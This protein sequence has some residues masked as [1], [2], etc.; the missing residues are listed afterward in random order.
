M[1]SLFKTVFIIMFFSVVTRFVGF[2]FRIYMSRT[3]GAEALGQYQVSFSVFM[4]LLTIVSSGLPFVM[5][6]LTAQYE[7]DKDKTGQHKMVTAGVIIGIVASVVLCGL[8]LLFLPVLKCVFADDNCITILLILLPALVFSSVYSTIRGNVWGKGHYF[9]L[10]LTE[11]F[12]QIS[13]VV[14]FII[15]I[16]GMLGNHDGSVVSAVSMTVACLLSSILVLVL[17]FARGGRFKFKKDK[18]MYSNLLKKSIPITGVRIAGSLVQPLIA[19]VVPLR[20]LS[21]GY[22]SS[23]ALSLYGTAM[24][25]TIPF[26]FIPSTIIGS[27]S[28]ALVPDLSSALYKND[29]IYIKNRVITAVKFTIFISV[30]FIPLYMG[31]GEFIGK[32]FYD[33]VTSGI[34]LTQSAWVML[35]LGIT[36]V[37]SSLLNSLGYE[38]KSMRNYTLG[39]ILLIL[40]IWFLPAIM[41]INSLIVGFGVCFIITSC[42]NLKMIC[43]ILGSNLNLK[44]YLILSIVFVL[45]CASI[46]SFVCN[47]LANFVP[48]FFSLAISCSLGALFYVLL[49]FIFNLIEINKFTIATKIKL[50]QIKQNLFK[51]PKKIK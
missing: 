28:T 15:L 10:C 25:M 21:A 44:K 37:T 9:E 48:L 20:L 40:S 36:N 43:K 51:K 34:M 19:L 14:I 39:A 50:K 7:A 8:V 49:C 29:M 17:Y 13:R 41:G 31:A 3:I 6:R 27:L 16:S 5:S 42:L 47:L 35:P 32:F 4:V 38:I 45:P 33:N 1:K 2:F 46:T 18:K 12:E 26:L 24:G 22:T 30:L 11:L 23:Q